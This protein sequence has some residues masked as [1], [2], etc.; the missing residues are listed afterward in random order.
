[1]KTAVAAEMSYTCMVVGQ[2]L[3]CA[4][5]LRPLVSDT[6]RQVSF[7]LSASAICIAAARSLCYLS[8]CRGQEVTFLLLA[9]ACVLS[10]RDD[11]HC[12]Q[13][14]TSPLPR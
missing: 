13:F 6:V 12:W 2:Q 4:F 11:C 14:N 10:E 8:T 9:R 7:Q 5:Q 1:M 3:T